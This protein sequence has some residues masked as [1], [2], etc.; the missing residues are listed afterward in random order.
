MS[1]KESRYPESTRGNYS[2]LKSNQHNIRHVRRLKILDDVQSATGDGRPKYFERC[3]LLLHRVPSI[4]YDDVKSAKRSFLF[5]RLQDRIVFLTA[6]GN[7]AI[8]QLDIVLLH[9]FALRFPSQVRH[10]NAS[11]S[12]DVCNGF[13]S[14][15]RIEA[16]SGKTKGGSLTKSMSPVRASLPVPYQ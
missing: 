4:V 10:T 9:A 16:F 3:Q 2:N 7:G 12:W 13:F 6:D 1:V 15:N 5:C 11:N 8:A 14:L